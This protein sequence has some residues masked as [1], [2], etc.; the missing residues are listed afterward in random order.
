MI[1]L[2]RTLGDVQALI[3]ERVP[4]DIHLDYKRS[5]A[6][7][8]DKRGEIAK[9]VSAFAN[10]DGGVL[11]YGVE[12]DPVQHVPTGTDAGVDHGRFSREW[13]EHVIDSNIQPRIADVEISPIPIGPDRSLYA[14]RVPRSVSAAYQNA[15][16]NKY[17]KRFNFRSRPMEHYEIEDLRNRRLMVSGRLTVGIEAQNHM[18]SFVVANDSAVSL[19]DITFELPPELGRWLE[20]KKPNFFTRGICELAPNRRMAITWGSY[21]GLTQA[22]STDPKMFDIKASY[23]SQGGDSVIT[24][25]FHV[26]LL[27]YWNTRVDRTDLDRHGAKLEKVLKELVEE[28]KK[29]GSRTEQLARIAE[30]TG[31]TLSVTA[32]RN[33][34]LLMSGAEP[35]VEKLDPMR[36]ELD[37]F[38]EVLGVSWDVALELDQYFNGRGPA[39]LDVIPGVTPELAD[40]VR[41]HFR[42]AD[43]APAAPTEPSDSGPE[44]A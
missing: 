16:D 18:V 17:Y 3:R 24:E 21:I 10:S 8:D 25:S 13:L 2:P 29:I 35:V 40:A 43:N 22:A 20:N 34:R 23:R 41:R 32:L 37:V 26:D 4:E 1:E 15:V 12:E 11:V 36:C 28:V 31:L 33:L 9:D 14:I 42:V 5:A 19:R 27:D 44:T 30:S 39:R 7:A 38:V 6:I